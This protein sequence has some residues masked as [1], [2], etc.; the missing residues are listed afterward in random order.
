[1][2][3]SKKLVFKEFLKSGVL[4]CRTHVHKL[5]GCAS[6][7]ENHNQEQVMSSQTVL[8]A[9]KG[10]YVAAKYR[11]AIFEHNGK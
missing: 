1:M 9:L 6:D 2:A 11:A 8:S 3:N 4:V 5:Q 7:V 10:S